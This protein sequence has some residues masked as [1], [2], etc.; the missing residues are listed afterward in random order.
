MEIHI[1]HSVKSSI[2]PSTNELLGFFNMQIFEGIEHIINENTLKLFN[3]LLSES[4]HS[5][6][7]LTFI[8]AKDYKTLENKFSTPAYKYLLSVFIS[9]FKQHIIMRQSEPITEFCYE[10]KNQILSHC[11]KIEDNI[12]NQYNRALMELRPNEFY[13]YK[14]GFSRYIPEG[15]LCKIEFTPL[16][17]YHKEI[18]VLWVE[19][20]SIRV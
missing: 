8:S 18:P 11:E 13:F 6:K 10:V 7:M 16:Y 5:R 15:I 20:E 17:A 4:H 12:F 14:K 9:H 1:I 19:H 3:H 2:I